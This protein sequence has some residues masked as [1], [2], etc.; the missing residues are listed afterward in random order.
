VG[1]PTDY[2]LRAPTL[3]DLLAV[4]DVLAASDLEAAG[5]IVLGPEFVKRDWTRDEFDLS[6]DAWVAVD[7]AG[8]VVAYGV[9]TRDEPRIARS[10]G[11]VHPAHR[12]RGI[13]SALLDRIEERASNLLAARPGG[14][15]RPA[16]DAG[17][18]T[19]AEMLRARGLQPVRHFW[20]MEI[21]LDGPIEPGPSP[22]GIDITGID[23]ELDLPTVQAV[24]EDAMADHWGERRMP[25]EEWIEDMTDGPGYDPALWMLAKVTGRAVGALT[26]SSGERGWVDYL[27]V[28]HT[29]R[30]RGIGA[31]LLRRSFALFAE[32]G[33]RQ[34]L[35]NVDAENVTGA[36][37]LYERVGMR[38]ANR[39]DM[40][41]RILP[42]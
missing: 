11:V 16:V 37:A 32:R 12:G 14:R 19:A 29:Y 21:D 25:F 7:M 42:D 26:A 36:T 9:V 30:G 39:W 6:T 2:E 8:N 10:W 41:E 18:S 38:V 13:G 22:E 1:L 24:I 33:I 35:V 34:V 3:D 17:D 15:F 28:L 20:H 27:G 4:A 23:P 5:Q 40:W 31:A